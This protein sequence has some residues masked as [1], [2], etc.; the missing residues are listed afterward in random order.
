MLNRVFPS[1]PVGV[2]VP[3]DVAVSFLSSARTEI[4]SRVQ[5]TI[6]ECFCFNQINDCVCYQKIKQGLTKGFTEK[7]ASLSGSEVVNPRT[8]W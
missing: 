4:Y 8:S 6:I 5:F 3:L 7:T 1:F 2:H